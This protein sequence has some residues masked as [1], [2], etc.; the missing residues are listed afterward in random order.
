MLIMND[1][2]L[3]KEYPMD[4]HTYAINKFIRLWMEKIDN[5]TWEKLLQLAKEQNCG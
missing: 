4:W 1:I 3:D 5:E 2:D